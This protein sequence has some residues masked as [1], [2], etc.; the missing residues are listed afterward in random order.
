MTPVRRRTFAPGDRI[1]AN[2]WHGFTGRVVECVLRSDP[3][4]VGYRVDLHGEIVEIPA[5]RAMEPDR[6]WLRAWRE[7]AAQDAGHDF[8]AWLTDEQLAQLR[9]EY[10]EQHPRARSEPWNRFVPDR[11]PGYLA[12]HLVKTTR[13]SESYEVTKSNGSC[14]RTRTR[15][16]WWVR[17]LCG[18]VE[19][20]ES[21]AAARDLK[22][23]HEALPAVDPAQ[24]R[25]A[26]AEDAAGAGGSVPDTARR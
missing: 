25:Q 2:G 5:H 7:W 26:A 13:T 15:Y 18:F 12:L 9:A 6:P 23:E 11:V 24:Y 21:A 20:R 16:T 19:V 17:C 4:F 3:P 10:I 22:T 1:T 8:V 14:L